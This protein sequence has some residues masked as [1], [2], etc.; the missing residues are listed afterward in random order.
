MTRPPFHRS[1]G[2]CCSPL[3]IISVAL[4]VAAVVRNDHAYL[5]YLA[6][7]GTMGALYMLFVR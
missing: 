7:T 5:G 6:G 3:T 2:Q 1:T 4:I